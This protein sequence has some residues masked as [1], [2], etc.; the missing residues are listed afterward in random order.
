M[1]NGVY[2]EKK[3]HEAD[4]QAV[5]QRARSM[6]VSKTISTAGSLDDVRRTLQIL[7]TSA[8]GLYMTAGVHPTRA[9]EFTQDEREEA[10]GLELTP[11]EIESIGGSTVA[12]GECGLDYARLKFSTK[13]QQME[14]FLKQLRI[15]SHPLVDLP[16]FLHCRDTDGEFLRVMTENR[17]LYRR[18]GGVVHSYDGSV[19]EMLAFC[20]LGLYIGING[21]SLR[22]EQSAD[23]IRA[24]PSD[25]ILL[26]TDAP[27]CGIKRT[28]VHHDLVRTSFPA[29]GI[30]K[31]EK[32]ISGYLVKDRNE[33]CYLHQVVEVVA[34]LRETAVE[35]LAEQVWSNSQ[36]L[37]FF[38]E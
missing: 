9:D 19:E 30:K 34:A 38:D 5:L 27:W 24:I 28:H 4:L 17:E 23:V 2:N 7:R 26:E 6:N 32:W 1:F 16:L 3:R 8:Y 31:K 10:L 15:A 20:E 18:R 12:L 33:P 22:S 29:E 21:C 11:E 13:E 25:R 14:G 37:F 36:R 35:E